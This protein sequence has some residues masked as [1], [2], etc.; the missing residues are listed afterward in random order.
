MNLFTSINKN[1]N[2]T[3]CQNGNLTKFFSIRSMPVTTVNNNSSNNKK[4]LKK[5]FNTKY[6]NYCKNIQSDKAVKFKYLYKNFQN[7]QETSNLIISSIKKKIKNKIKPQILNI[8][9]TNDNLSNKILKKINLLKFDPRVSRNGKI[10]KKYFSINKALGKLN[11]IDLVIFDNFISNIPNINDLL[12]KISKILNTNG[13]ILI[14]THYGISN[15]NKVDLNRFYFEHINY[16]SIKGLLI[17]L[18]NYDL[19]LKDLRFTENNNF[20]I[21]K[22]SKKQNYINKD[23]RRILAEE[24]KVNKTNFIK[25]NKKI[26]KNTSVLK[27]IIK[28]KY[29]IY[30]YGCSIGSTTQIKNYNLQNKIKQIIDDKPIN[31]F[32]LIDKFKLRVNRLENIKFNNNKKIVLNF[33]P[34]HENKIFYKLKKYLNKGDIFVNFINNFIVKVI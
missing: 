20:V 33:I 34:R 31:N 14:Y 22:F 5:D 8:G 30:G 19:Y 1:N 28:K 16:F 11:N 18:K 29:D 23:L 15:L 21:L 6:C 9:K 3:I 24:E 27:K 12:K 10:K 4:Y 13:E 17:L 26:K 7:K 25:F 32:M 2:C